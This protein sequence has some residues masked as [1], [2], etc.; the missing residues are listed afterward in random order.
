MADNITSKHIKTFFKN[1]ID[2]T[3][4]YEDARE[5]TLNGAPKFA[6]LPL[7]TQ[8]ALQR[9]EREYTD[10]SGDTDTESSIEAGFNLVMKGKYQYQLR[11]KGKEE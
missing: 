1:A 6:D 5:R 2:G 9:K 7:E 3:D 11:L 10:L 8:R 4:P